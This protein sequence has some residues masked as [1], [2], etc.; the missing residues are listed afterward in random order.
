M[1]KY[2]LIITVFTFF[3]VNA[4]SQIEKGSLMVGG[5][6]NF[7]SANYS[8]PAIANYTQT[9]WQISADAGYFFFNKFAA[10]LKPGYTEIINSNL[11][12]ADGSRNSSSVFN[13]GPF[14]RYYF[15]NS[16]NRINI[17]GEV[18]YQYQYQYNTNKTDAYSL[19]SH[20]SHNAYSIEAGPVVYL[21]PN[22][23]V[24][25]SIGYSITKY[26]TGG[27]KSN[28]VQVGIGFQIYLGTKKNHYKHH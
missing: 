3:T 26:N 18:D 12:A 7:S 1:K 6:A 8:A 20:D 21:N 15:L 11:A 28:T 10:G 2:F 19:D 9:N 27:T 17:F 13:I 25:F 22:V 16:K 14:I 4:Y 24:E 5:S 23:D